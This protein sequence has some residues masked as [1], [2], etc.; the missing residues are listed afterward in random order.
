MTQGPE[1]MPLAIILGD[2]QG[3]GV[4]KIFS[5]FFHGKTYLSLSDLRSSISAFAPQR[6]SNENTFL[7]TPNYR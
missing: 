5:K 6:R 7:D 1:N 3:H 4:E 2:L